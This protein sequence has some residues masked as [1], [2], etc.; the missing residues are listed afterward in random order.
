[1]LQM[2]LR[3]IFFVTAL[4]FVL[5]SLHTQASATSSEILEDPLYS[6]KVKGGQKEPLFDENGKL[7]YLE[8]HPP[9]TQD[10]PAPA[11][12]T[13]ETPEPNLQ[14]KPGV[15]PSNTFSLLPHHVRELIFEALRDDPKAQFNLMLISHGFRRFVFPL[16]DREDI[17]P[18]TSK[19]LIKHL[20]LVT[21]G[22]RS[23]D[24][25]TFMQDYGAAFENTSIDKLRF[26]LKKHFF[27]SVFYSS[28]IHKNE[29]KSVNASN[30]KDTDSL[31]LENFSSLV[32]LNFQGI[33][34][35]RE[36][37]LSNNSLVV[38]PPLTHLTNLERL[39]LSKNFFELPPNL[40]GLT[41][42][43]NLNMSQNSL[44]EA[45]KVQHMPLRYLDLSDNKINMAPNLYGLTKLCHLDL[46]NNKLWGPPDLGS[47]RELS[48]VR[49]E[50]NGFF[51]TPDISGMKNLFELHIDV[52]ALNG[53]N[54]L[55]YDF[56]GLRRNQSEQNKTQASLYTY[57]DELDGTP[58]SKWVDC[59]N[60]GK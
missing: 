31:K 3:T 39:D 58:K 36:L 60:V 49:L 25:V 8:L 44:T 28:S 40:R 59:D 29:Y 11:T 33:E 56:R 32:P 1:M 4:S 22:L 19:G 35:I 20:L 52:C 27:H 9:K 10:P 2:S 14:N 13:P 42:L 17:T 37:I 53:R 47:L 38:L 15:K 5:A 48:V 46:S 18:Q 6:R 54:G 55:L 26:Y 30:I 24:V 50:N 16:P 51:K 23:L 7:R 43:T 41:K 34:R 57:W 45:P 12:Q 21:L